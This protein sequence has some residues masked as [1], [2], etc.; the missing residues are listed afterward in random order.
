M[1]QG[2]GQ[3]YLS[4]FEVASQVFSRAKFDPVY[5]EYFEGWLRL[6][7]CYWSGSRR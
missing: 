6:E 5:K 4:E 7:V 2:M 1:Q 3:T